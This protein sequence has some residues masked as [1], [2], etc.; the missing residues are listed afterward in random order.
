MESAEVA[1]RFLAFFEERGHTGGALGKPG[2]R[3][4]DAAARQR[5]HGA[6]QAVLPRPAHPAVAAGDQRAEVRAHTRH[7]RGRQDHPARHVLP[8]VGQL[9][10]RGLLQGG[11]HP[12]RVGAAHPAAVATAGTA[13]P[14]RSS[15]SP[16]TRTTT[17]PRASGA[18]RSASPTSGSSAAGW[19]T[20]TGTWACPAPAAPARRSTTTA[21]PSTATRAARSSTR[22]ATWRSGTSSSCSR[23]WARSAARSTSTS[24]GELPAKNIDTGMGLERMAAILQGVD[25]IYETDTLRR[26]LDRAAELTGARY[27][28]RPCAPTCRCASSPTTSAAA[29]MLVA[30]RR[31]ARPTRA[32][33]TCCAA[34]CAAPSATCGCSAPRDAGSCTS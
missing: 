18:T 28:A 22:T 17:R 32:A 6:V 15:G 8:D 27:G 13:S 31:H 5:R 3:R 19:P 12:L 33:A 14:R 34:S 11:R 16:S 20:T 4:P 30:R 29:T 25:N 1:R 21:G 7:R 9:L 2:R 24:P 23:S 10:V 26:I